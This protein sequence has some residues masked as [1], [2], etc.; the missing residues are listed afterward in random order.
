MNAIMPGKRW[1]LVS[2]SEKMASGD[3]LRAPAAFRKSTI[4]AD[5][6]LAGP[7]IPPATPLLTLA[8]LL[9]IAPMTGRGGIRQPKMRS[10]RAI[11]SIRIAKVRYFANRPGSL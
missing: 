2:E 11:R 9:P 7:S 8:P 6:T 1:G 3:H 10:A 5:P 4:V